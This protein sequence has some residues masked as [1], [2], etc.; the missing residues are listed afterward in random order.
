[1]PQNNRI[2]SGQGKMLNFNTVWL[3]LNKIEG[4]RI[5][6]FTTARGRTM[7][8][9]ALK[10]PITYLRA[11]VLPLSGTI[12][13]VDVVNAAV[14]LHAPLP[15]GRQRAQS[16]LGARR[17][18]PGHNRSARHYRTR[19]CTR[20]RYHSCPRTDTGDHPRTHIWGSVCP[21]TGT[22]SCNIFSLCNASPTYSSNT[23]TDNR[24]YVR[25]N[26]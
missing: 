24:E 7:A 25:I 6:L 9:R 18:A 19:N 1:M 4:V 12:L 26:R 5:K 10:I 23:E 21:R 16:V 8:V 13:V 15:A 22:T 2:P 3:S 14:V 11:W 20:A 17:A